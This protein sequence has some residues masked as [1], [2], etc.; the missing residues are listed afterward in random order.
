MRKGE[1]GEEQ[2][3]TQLIKIQSFAHASCVNKFGIEC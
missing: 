3:T 2:G 1:R